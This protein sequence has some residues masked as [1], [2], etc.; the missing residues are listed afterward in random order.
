MVGSWENMT[1]TSQEFIILRVKI[2]VG[3]TKLNTI[4]MFIY[5]NIRIYI[6]ISLFNAVAAS[7]SSFRPDIIFEI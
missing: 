6:F 4:F 2:E 7:A 3:D 1:C 5:I